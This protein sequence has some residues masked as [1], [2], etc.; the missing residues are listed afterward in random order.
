MRRSIFFR[1]LGVTVL[2]AVCSIAATAWLAAQITRASLQQEQGRELAVDNDI[3]KTL[4]GYAV[5][6]SDWSEASGIVKS[7]VEQYPNR[8]IVLLTKDRTPIVDLGGDGSPLPAT[9]SAEVDALDVDP[10]LL[11]DAAADRIDKRVLGPFRTPIGVREREDLSG[12]L[13]CLRSTRLADAATRQKCVVDVRLPADSVADFYA[14]L[15]LEDLV[16]PCLARRNLP[17]VQLDPDYTPAR[18]QQI[19]DEPTVA[20]CV[21][22]SRQ[23][24]LAPYVAP[25]A[26]L[27]VT[28]PAGAATTSFDLSSGNWWRVAGVAGAVFL[29]AIVVTAAVCA[30]LIRPLRALTG[31]AHLMA[32]GDAAPRLTVR[33]RDE[34][35]QLTKAFNTMVENRE[36]MEEVRKAM[37]S[38]IAHELR[39]PLSNIRGWLEAAEDGLSERDPA[40]IALLLKEALVLQHVVDDLQDLAAADA[41]KLRLNRSQVAVPEVFAQLYAAHE[42]RAAQ[43]GITLTV[44]S[45]EELQVNA[46]PVRLRQMLDNLVTNALRHVPTGGSVVLTARTERD[47]VVFEVADTGTGIDPEDLPHVFDR[48]WRAEKSRSRQTGGSG[49]GLAIVRKLAEAHGGSAIAGSAPGQGATFRIRF[50]A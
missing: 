37:V 16:N 7:L 12:S 22:S 28:S 46:D 27:F 41:G 1:L 50:P 20:E 25:A 38:D 47:E 39:T 4:L 35:A 5:E 36:R 42:A 9:A 24:Q 10:V 44:S 13:K 32:D 45:P 17:P 3:Y 2:V 31:A 15:A 14:L 48:F 40:L 8:R 18:Y 30:R 33:G 43:N 21:K 49:L 6:H 34:I 29:V 19:P 11:P 23:Q 26:L